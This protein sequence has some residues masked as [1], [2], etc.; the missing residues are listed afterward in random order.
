MHYIKQNNKDLK[1]YFFI[2]NIFF[3]FTR[4]PKCWVLRRPLR[5]Y[6]SPLLHRKLDP[7]GIKTIVVK[8]S[9]KIFELWILA[10]QI[11]LN[12][13]FENVCKFFFLQSK[14]LSIKVS[15]NNVY[16]HPCMIWHCKV[17]ITLAKQID[18]ILFYLKFR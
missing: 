14:F 5:N 8:L 6:A 18:F 10:V 12:Q 3:Q 15:K 4:W 17:L 7:K 2:W 11:S 16:N 13:T 1:T 9:S